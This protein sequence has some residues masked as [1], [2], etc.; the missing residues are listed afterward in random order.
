MKLFETF[1]LGSLQL[2]NRVVMA[3]LT[4]SRA[5]GNIPN[6]LMAEYYGQRANAGLI[7]TEG[8]SPSPNG[9]GYARIPGCYTQEQA[10]GWKGVTSTVH[11]KKG[12]IFLQ[13]MH[14]GRVSHEA[15]L[16]KGGK[17]LAPSALLLSGQMWTD[18]NGMQPYTMPREM[19]LAEI[20]TAVTEFVHSADLAIRSGF[21]GIELHAANGYLLE[22]FLNP[23]ANHRTDQYGG[24]AENRMRFVLE[25]AAGVAQKIGASQ[26]GIRISP[27]GVFNDMKPFEGIDAFYGTLSQKLSDIG[28]AYIHVVDHSSMGAPE[29]SGIPPKKRTRDFMRLSPVV[30]IVSAS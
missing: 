12:H 19:T 5:I 13:L 16:P 20:Q 23:E 17:V 25:V 18:E 29:V 6:A 27:Y 14:C 2:K 8:T 4:R 3:P 11:V 28:L 21:D 1:N 30:Q 22:Q 10:D 24:S 7:I 15:N 9:V 26:V